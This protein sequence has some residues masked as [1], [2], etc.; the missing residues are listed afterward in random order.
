MGEQTSLSRAT[1]NVVYNLTGNELGLTARFVRNLC[2]PISEALSVT[3]F[4]QVMFGDINSICLIT[5]EAPTLVMVKLVDLEQPNR[6][7][8]ILIPVEELGE[9]RRP[10]GKKGWTDERKLT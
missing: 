10:V 7:T 3:H 6:E 9:L 8:T 2:E 4:H 5:R 1:Q